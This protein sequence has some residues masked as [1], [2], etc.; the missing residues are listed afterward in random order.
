MPSTVI[1]KHKRN[2][3]KPAFARLTDHGVQ[4]K[5]TNLRKTRRP[6]ACMLQS[7]RSNSV[8]ETAHGDIATQHRPTV[9]DRDLTNSA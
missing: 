1:V 5:R 7:Y 9:N 6:R 3:L 8:D 4:K 2:G